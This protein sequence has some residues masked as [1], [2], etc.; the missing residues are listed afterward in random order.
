M[1]G[2]EPIKDIFDQYKDKLCRLAL[3]ISHNQADAEDIT[4]NAFLKIMKNIGRFRGQSKL[5]T[6]MY[7][8]TYNE[9]LMYLRKKKRQTRLI[10]P[11]KRSAD[12]IFVN[13]AKIPDRALLDSELKERIDNVL[14]SMPIQYRIP[15][16]LHAVEALPIKEAAHIMGLK[17][18]TFKTRL[19]RAHGAIAKEWSKY[20]RDMPL[21]EP[22]NEKTCGRW[23]GF[24]SDLVAGNFDKGRYSA[25]KK[26]INDCPPCK[27]F[28]R[29]YGEALSLTKALQCR[30]VPPELRSKIDSFISLEK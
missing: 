4:Q 11:L 8:I 2:V 27:V 29:S 1:P 15:L 14:A 7:K 20:D 18:N 23:T 25:F 28:L 24:T 10:E 30:D 19:N 16:L 26:H 3:S 21:I 6:W 12:R 22:R 5:S 9:A 17:T 13:W